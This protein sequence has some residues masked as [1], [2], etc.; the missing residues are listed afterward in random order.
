M[1]RNVRI[2][3]IQATCTHSGDA[4]PKVIKQAMIEKH[5]GYIEEAARAALRSSVSRSY[6][7]ARTSPRNRR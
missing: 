7:L 6:F 2:G 5:I 1:A 4:D 3:L